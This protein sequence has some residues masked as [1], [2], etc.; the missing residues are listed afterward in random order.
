MRVYLGRKNP[1]SKKQISASYT[2][3]SDGKFKPIENPK[4]TLFEDNS[5]NIKTKRVF[6]CA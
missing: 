2:Y 4:F 3:I 5:F 6:L 1:D